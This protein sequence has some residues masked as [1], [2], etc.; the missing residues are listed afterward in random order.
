MLL[1]PPPVINCHTFS[2]PIPL[3]RGVLYGRPPIPKIDAYMYV[4]SALPQFTAGMMS[5][6]NDP[7]WPSCASFPFWGQ[8][9]SSRVNTSTMQHRAF[10]VVAPSIWNSL[11]SQIRLLPKS[12]TPLLYKLLQTD[13]FHLDWTE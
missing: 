13:L 6:C 12:Y 9:R 7:G 10:S 11:L 4:F 8:T 2:D 5:S 3:E 1:T